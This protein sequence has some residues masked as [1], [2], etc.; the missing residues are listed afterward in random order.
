MQYNKTWTC[1]HDSCVLVYISLF[2]MK[3]EV[4]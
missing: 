1:E 3:L 2:V 4:A